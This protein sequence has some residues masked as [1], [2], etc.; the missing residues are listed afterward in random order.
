MAITE[1]WNQVLDAAEAEATRRGHM[2]VGTGHLLLKLIE[3]PAGS[4][5]HYLRDLNADITSIRTELDDQLST[6]VARSEE[7]QE[8]RLWALVSVGLASGGN[9]GALLYGVA[10]KYTT[11]GSEVLGHH[12]IYSKMLV[13]RRVRHA[14]L[15]FD[16]DTPLETHGNPEQTLE[17]AVN[18][19]IPQRHIEILKLILDGR[20][21]GEISERIAMSTRDF[22]M[23]VRPSLEEMLRNG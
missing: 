21:E 18:L 7:Y 12:G 4:A 17:R 15:G 9:T 23:V 19:G 8:T 10:R 6:T 1:R 16:D 13:A 5:A 14:L 3:Q 22:W 11:L 2:H 20:T